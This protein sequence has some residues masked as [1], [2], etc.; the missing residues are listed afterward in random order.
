ME[1]D[2]VLDRWMELSTQTAGD[3]DGSVHK[4]MRPVAFIHLLRSATRHVPLRMSDEVSCADGH[5][6]N[7]RE[8]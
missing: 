5:Q 4:S 3:E 6:K 1:A 2:F 8:D 7:F